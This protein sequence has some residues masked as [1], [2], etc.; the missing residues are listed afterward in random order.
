MPGCSSEE[1]R[2]LRRQAIDFDSSPP[3]PAEAAVIEFAQQVRLREESS[4]EKRTS[5]RHSVVSVVPAIELDEQLNP[6]CEPFTTIC[7]NISKG[8]ICLL[9][10]WAIMSD[11]AI[12]FCPANQQPMQVLLRV[13]R[14][15][16]L[17]PYHD[18]GGEFVHKMSAGTQG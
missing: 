9:N 4:I 6:A 14:R 18:I 7:R 3:A 1:L 17:G 13:L 16:P 11:L 2:G 10:E 12:E 8:G 5:N 15:R